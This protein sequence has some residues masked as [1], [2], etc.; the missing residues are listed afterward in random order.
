MMTLLLTLDPASSP[1]VPHSCGVSVDY[2][3]VR[4]TMI[5]EVESELNL[6]VNI[7]GTSDGSDALQDDWLKNDHLIGVPLLRS[8]DY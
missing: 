1:Q 6:L 4:K 8:Y 5:T 3:F 2:D 7:F